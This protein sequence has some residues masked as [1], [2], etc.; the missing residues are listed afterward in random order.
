MRIKNIEVEPLIT[1]LMEMELKGR[2]SRFRTRFVKLLMERQ[3]LIEGEHKDLIKQFSSI[4]EDGQPNTIEQNGKSFYDV[5]D[6]VGFNKEYFMLM[7]E[8]F[9]IEETEER[10]EML[11]LLKDV[12]LNCEMTFMGGEALKYDRWCDIFEE[13]KYD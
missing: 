12:I 10:K 2:D 5:Q 13:I 7:N 3:T 4:G 1:F 8:D 6:K 9:I 11:I